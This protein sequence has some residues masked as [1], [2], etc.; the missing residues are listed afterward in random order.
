MTKAGSYGYKLPWETAEEDKEAAQEAT[1]SLAAAKETS[2]K[3]Q[4]FY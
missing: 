3:E 2:V 4:Q 1:P